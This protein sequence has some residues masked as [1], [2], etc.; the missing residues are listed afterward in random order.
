MKIYPLLFCFTALL[1][2]CCGKSKQE[3]LIKGTLPSPQYDG[4]WIYLVPMKDAPGRVDSIKIA[5]A[6]FNF[7]GEGEEMKVLRLRPI[8]RLRIQE[9]LIVT[10]PGDI[11]I[12]ADSIGS[13]SGT[14]QNDALQSWK[15]E[16]EKRQA[17]FLS[18]RETLSEDS[19]RLAQAYDM[20]HKEEQET[21][22]LFLKTQ[23]N[24][25]LGSFMWQRLYHLLT[26]E[27]KKELDASHQQK[28]YN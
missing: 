4:E 28:T 21:N 9:L 10:E 7:K 16:R 13:V 14:P 19:V 26:E 8:L 1:L 18:L 15:E 23:G 3:Y 2:T 5:D 22:F 27:Q 6:S 11:N 12:T 25:T 17:T 20:L 24:N